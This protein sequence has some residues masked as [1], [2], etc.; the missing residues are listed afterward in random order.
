VESP[1]SILIWNIAQIIGGSTY[2]M[3]CR[4]RTD[5]TQITGSI[6]PKLNIELHHNF[7][8]QDSYVAV[9]DNVILKQ[10][11]ITAALAK[12]VKFQIDNPQIINS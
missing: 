12:P 8:I 7:T 10:A 2:Q 3:N 11:P 5:A 4:L 6:T 1:Q 9:V